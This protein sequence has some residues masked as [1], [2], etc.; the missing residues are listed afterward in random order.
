MTAPVSGDC[1]HGTSA[2]SKQERTCAICFS[3]RSYFFGFGF[4]SLLGVSQ[5]G[6]FSIL[7]LALHLYIPFFN[8]THMV[9]F[10]SVPYAKETKAKKVSRAINLIVETIKQ[11]H[12]CVTSILGDH[13]LAKLINHK[14]ASQG[15][16]A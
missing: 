14:K 4:L 5:Q 8:F 1:D 12:G 10:G 7:P 6:V 9:S 2:Q 16:F 15:A 13:N 3:S 11:I